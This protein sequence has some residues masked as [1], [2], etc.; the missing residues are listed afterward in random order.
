MLEP[1]PQCLHAGLT[2]AQE[3]R[4]ALDQRFERLFQISDILDLRLEIASRPKTFARH[5]CPARRGL[6]PQRN[7]EILHRGRHPNGARRPARGR[8]SNSPM[9]VTPMARKVCNR[10]ISQA[11]QAMGSPARWPGS[12]PRSSMMY[13]AAPAGCRTRR[14][15][16]ATAPP[17]STGPWRCTPA[18]Q[19]GANRHRCRHAIRS[20]EPN[21]FKLPL[22]SNNKALGGSMLTKEVNRLC[23]QAEPLQ[24]GG[25]MFCFDQFRKY[26]G[27]PKLL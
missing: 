22:I 10:S 4:T 16:A 7:V 14:A 18:A 27:I 19:A 15:R 9:R 24:Y 25:G 26:R 5:E 8:R 3:L 13:G 12:S 17:K 6:P 21:S 2:L 20:S 23:M 1:Q 11:V